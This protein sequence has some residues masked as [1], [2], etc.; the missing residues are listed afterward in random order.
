MTKKDQSK[1]KWIKPEKI[2]FGNNLG[3]EFTAAG[4]DIGHQC[5]PGNRAVLLCNGGSDDTGSPCTPGVGA[6]E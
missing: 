5:G 6:A 4:Y 2:V 1:I 3:H